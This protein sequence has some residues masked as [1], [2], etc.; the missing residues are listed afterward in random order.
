MFI[1][2]FAR[3]LCRI[4]RINVLTIEQLGELTLIQGEL[5][6]RIEST[7]VNISISLFMAW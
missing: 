6:V 5:I 4:R 7:I 3:R 1:K 2:Q